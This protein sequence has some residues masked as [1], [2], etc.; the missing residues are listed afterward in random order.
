M[1]TEISGQLQLFYINMRDGITFELLYC[2]HEEVDQT[3]HTHNHITLA[4]FK[5][6]VCGCI[7]KYFCK[8]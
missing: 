5:I 7:H 8:F 4:E 3:Q 6:K 1:V 2:N